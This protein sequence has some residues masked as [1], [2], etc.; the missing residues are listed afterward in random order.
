MSDRATVGVVRPSPTVALVPSSPAPTP[1]SA[2]ARQIA[3]VRAGLAARDQVAYRIQAYKGGGSAFGATL[4][5][6]WS[7][8]ALALDVQDTNVLGGQGGQLRWGYGDKVTISRGATPMDVALTDIQL[9]GL[10]PFAALSTLLDALAAP[11]WRV[12]GATTAQLASGDALELQLTGPTATRRLV[13]FYTQRP[14]VAYL[15][16]RDS[17]GLALQLVYDGF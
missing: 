4:Q 17:S 13:G 3:R 16:E 8:S 12:T 5:A 6:R 1:A 2:L 11:G 9:A 14:F 10:L 7:A 15:E